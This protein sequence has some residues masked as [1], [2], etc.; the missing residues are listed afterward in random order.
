MSAVR[1][2]GLDLYY[3]IWTRAYI[4]QTINLADVLVTDCH[5]GVRCPN[6]VPKE[7][8]H[9]RVI[10]PPRLLTIIKVQG[11][12]VHPHYRRYVNITL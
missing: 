11:G 12:G 4:T 2:P 5:V 8:Q 9:S 1:R 3:K 7:G 10:T 6:L